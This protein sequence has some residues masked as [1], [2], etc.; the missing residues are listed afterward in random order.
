M[1][2]RVSLQFR[3]DGPAVTGEWADE[4]TARRIWRDWVGLY[5]SDDSVVIRLVEESDGQEQEL[6]AWKHGQVAGG[7]PNGSAHGLPGHICG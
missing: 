1:T 4:T 3:A 7:E 6:T 2:Y 5:G